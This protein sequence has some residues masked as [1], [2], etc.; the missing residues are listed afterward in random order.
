[1][2]VSVVVGGQFGSEGKGKVALFLAKER[3]ARVAV[4]VGGTNSGHTVIDHTGKPIIF[5]HL[6][7]ACLLPQIINV[8]PP[9][10]YVHVPTLLEEIRR[11]GSPPERIA[12]DPHAWIIDE[13]DVEAEKGNGLKEAI[14]STATGT[15]AS[16]VRRIQRSKSGP[17]AKDIPAL[18]VYVRDTSELLSRALKNDQRII[19]EG[20]QGFGLSLL[21]SGFYP[22]TTSRDT[23]ASAFVS[24]AGLSPL[25][26]DEVVL[27]IR[28]FPIRV[29]GTSGPLPNEID[30]QTVTLES[31][32]T[33][34]LVEYTSVTNRVR[35]VAR[36]DPEI[37]KR[38]I[39]H[40]R[41]TLIVMNHFDYVDANCKKECRLT[42]KALGF[43]G[44]VETSI[45][46]RLSLLGFGADSLAWRDIKHRKLGNEGKLSGLVK[47]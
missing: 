8:I 5:R 31:G 10:N 36:F 39:A 32:D 17:F 15:G 37:V 4:R 12:I 29:A 7:T 6:P 26:V 22:Y 41:P 47:Y 23:T 9:G 27:V 3:E 2:P 34:K 25:D 43:I 30:W 45:G 19:L 13:A 14:G 21:H 28:A 11:V 18:R 42:Q 35:R 44:H 20:T 24:E 16:L 38:A 1:M 46:N 40:N 33:N